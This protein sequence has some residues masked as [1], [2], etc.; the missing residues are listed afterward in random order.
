[1]V[2]R[3]DR[4]DALEQY[5]RGRVQTL[6]AE[7]VVNSLAEEDYAF[8]YLIR[9]TNES[10]E[11]AAVSPSPIFVQLKAS[12]EFDDPEFVLWDF[13]T[14]FLVD[15]CLASPVPVGLFIYE[16]SGDSVN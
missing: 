6:L 5:S 8:D 13:D 4:K 10:T 9:P 11:P 1:M 7:C 14:D 3:K 2:K 15:D 12:R 16:Q